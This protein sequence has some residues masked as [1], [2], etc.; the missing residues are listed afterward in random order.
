MSGLELQGPLHDWHDTALAGR[1]TR[2]D[3]VRD[4]MVFLGPELQGDRPRD[5]RAASWIGRT[6]PGMLPLLAVVTL[7]KR[8]A[9]IYPRTT[10]LGLERLIR[11]EGRIVPFRVAAEIV[12]QVAEVLHQ[13]SSG[14]DHPG[15]LP[16]DVGVLSDGTVKICGFASP[17]PPDPAVEDLGGGTN[18]ESMVWRL[19]VLLSRLIGGTMPAIS[20][21]I[22]H[23]ARMRR[24]LIHAMS[25]EGHLFTERYR[26]WL[27]GMLHWAP[28]QRPALSAVAS[29]LRKLGAEVG[30][31]DLEM[32]ASQ[33]VDSLRN[34]SVRA[35]RDDPDPRDPENYYPWN[36][37]SVDQTEDDQTGNSA[38]PPLTLG[39]TL[40][41]LA[42]TDIPAR[43]DA[44]S[45][46]TL[47][48]YGS[49]RVIPQAEP[50]TMPIGIGPPV[51]AM[52]AKPTLPA[53]FLEPTPPPRR[54]P[55]STSAMVSAGLL[56]LLAGMTLALAILAAIFVWV[57]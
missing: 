23:Q 42:V 31:P 20:D 49:E 51:E 8:E 17:Y 26:D 18:D 39:T 21:E 27:T 15:P 43:D 14:S 29:G 11:A 34:T 55:P 1:W 47:R 35:H 36:D 5:S 56:A 25:R 9:W 16:A 41:G 45:E 10:A 46:S 13:L 6:G 48:A 38:A 12:A 24:L 22:S 33:N 30:G 3:E 37:P 52:R 4:V 32:W 28:G 19:G 40:P 44:T 57:S 50:G 2:G 7:G 53:G 54:G